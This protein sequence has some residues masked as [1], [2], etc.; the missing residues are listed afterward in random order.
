MLGHQTDAE[1]AEDKAKTAGFGGVQAIRHLSFFLDRWWIFVC[2]G[3]CLFYIGITLVFVSLGCLSVSFPVSVLSC[4]VWETMDNWDNVAQKVK[5]HQCKLTKDDGP[6]ER[7]WKAIK[8]TR[9]DL[10]KDSHLAGSGKGWDQRTLCKGD[11]RKPGQFVLA[12]A[13]W[14]DEGGS[15]LWVWGVTTDQISTFMGMASTPL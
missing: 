5:F 10:V 12:D 3:M 1:K 4:L 13:F 15:R 6:S 2:F 14:I 8:K 7:Q 9:T 11:A